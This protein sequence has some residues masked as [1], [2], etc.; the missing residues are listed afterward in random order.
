VVADKG[1]HSNEVVL[2]L[3]KFKAPRLLSSA[4]RRAA[5]PRTLARRRCYGGRLYRIRGE[6][7]LRGARDGIRHSLADRFLIAGRALLV[8]RSQAAV[9][10]KPVIHLSAVERRRRPV[11]AVA[12][13]GR[14]AS[15]RGAGMV[16]KAKSGSLRQARAWGDAIAE[17][18]A[19][20]RIEP[21]V[22]EAETG[23]GN[24]LRQVP[25]REAEALQHLQ[26]AV[27]I[28]P[29]F[30]PA[31]YNL[32]VEWRPFLAAHRKQCGSLR[33]RS[34]PAPIRQKCA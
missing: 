33:R 14:G 10:G 25:G 27:R 4:A 6:R 34:G 19:A 17:Y 3:D 32:G 28:A 1:Y 11:V 18:E 22:V 26:T 12:V 21:D 7:L 13:S 24:T 16:R 15:G 20:L 29:S 2:G 9:A 23:L 31:H 30:A 8:L 5:T